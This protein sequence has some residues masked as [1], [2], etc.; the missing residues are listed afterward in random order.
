M[1]K[2]NLEVSWGG[3]DRKRQ[4]NEHLYKVFFMPSINSF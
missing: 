4:N 2:K 1:K 3:G